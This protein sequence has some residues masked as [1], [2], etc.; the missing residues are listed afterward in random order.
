M[1]EAEAA[2]RDGAALIVLTDQAGS[3]DRLAAPMILATAGVH[4]RLTKAGLRTY[5]SIVVRTA[6][7]LDPHGFAVLVGVGATT[8]NAWLAQDL[9]Q[10]R[11]D[12][13]L[14][15]GLTLRDACLNYK[16]GIEAGLLK[17]LARKG[18][19]VIS[20]YRGGCEFEVLGL[21]RALTAEFFPGAPSRISGIG[22]AG[23][24]QAAMKRHKVAWGE[25]VPSPAI[26]GFLQDP[27]GRRGPRP[28]GQDHPPAAG[29]LQSRRL[30]PLQ[31][32]LGGRPRPGRPVPARSLGL[33][34][35]HGH[36]AGSGRERVGHPPPL[37]DP[38]HV[39]GRPGARGARDAEHRHE[40]HRRPFGLRRG[41]ARIPNAITR[42]RTAT[43]PTRPSNRW[44]RAGSASPPN[45]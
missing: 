19:S 4:G 34:R 20:A 2:A 31:A 18:I 9:F 6:E 36:S 30:P 10:E 3:A 25:A 11:L 35:R 43:T 1:D 5:C 14:Y 15:P 27:F 32:V 44:P 12:R 41:R 16:A 37:P 40:P 42:V 28:R 21:S 7:T 23:L 22:L 45:I 33:P 13:G 17:T 29:R 26:G 38:G 24:E 8:V 39:A